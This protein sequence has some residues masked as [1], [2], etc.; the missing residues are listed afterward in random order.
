MLG[1]WSA[2][3]ALDPRWTR[4][5]SRATTTEENLV[6]RLLLV[7]AAVAAF[8][9]YLPLA[10]LG[11]GSDPT[12]KAEFVG[13]IEVAGKSASLQVRYQCSSGENLWV[14]AKETKSGVSAT[15]LMKEGSSKV[16]AA[17]WESHRNKF[18]CNGRSHTGTFSIDTV[19]KGS[20]GALVPGSAWVQ[21]CVTTGHTEK[22]T[23]LTLSRSGW[24]KV[25]ALQ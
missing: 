7:A 25:A 13:A 21:F 14:S 5:S 3:D 9:V 8:A 15:K 16:S 2:S 10:A 18:A 4:P 1:K 6:R 12:A 11:A 19:E 17:W 24:V 23:V 22:D 20:K